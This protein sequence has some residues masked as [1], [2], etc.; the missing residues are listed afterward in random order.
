GRGRSLCCPTSRDTA[1]DYSRPP[2]LAP[3]RRHGRVRGVGAAQSGWAALRRA[4]ARDPAPRARRMA[5]GARGGGH[6]HRAARRPRGRP[7]DGPRAR[8][9]RARD[10]GVPR[11]HAR[12]PGQRLFRARALVEPGGRYRRAGAGARAG[13]RD[14]VAGPALGGDP[15]GQRDDAIRGRA[16]RAVSPAGARHS[17]RL[18]RRVRDLAG[19]A[20]RVRRHLR[21]ARRAAA[22]PGAGARDPG[23][24]RYLAGIPPPPQGRGVT[25]ERIAM[26]IIL[27]EDVQ[28]LG[29][30]GEIV[31]VKDGYARNYLLPKGL[32][33]PATEANK[34]RI[35]YEA[36]R[37]AKQRLAE[38]EAAVSEA[39]RLTGIE[40][41]FS[42]KVG[43]EDKLY[44]SVT[45]GDIQ[46]RLAEQELHVD[47]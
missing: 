6:E 39:Q 40:L 30:A 9:H 24:D 44:G 13:R 37:L 31:K 14:G 42:V 20:R 18:R 15:P 41:S 22:V 34:K 33:Y 25:I 10:R 5:A 8:L 4:D 35:T 12:R 38:K 7:A 11:G 3:G 43:E 16:G 29:R 1:V 28:H 26:E 19:G 46:R 45:A 23:R 27:R 21:G 36:E 32:A 2:A 17:D 47:K